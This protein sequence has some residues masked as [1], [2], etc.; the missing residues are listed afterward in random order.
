MSIEPYCVYLNNMPYIDNKGLLKL[1]CKNKNFG[2]PKEMN[3]TN[4]P[5][6]DLYSHSLIEKRREEFRQGIVPEGCHICTDHER[7]VGPKSFRK[8][9]L[10]NIKGLDTT[11]S[12]SF[13]ENDTT[14]RALDLRLG[15]TCN[16]VC[17]MCHPSES[18]KWYSISKDFSQEVKLESEEQAQRTKETNNPKFLNWAEYDQSWENIFSSIDENLLRIYLAGGEPFYIKKFSKYLE[19]ITE[20]S[21]NAFI[22]INTNATRMLTE[23]YVKKLKGKLNLRVSIDGYGKYDEYQRA[24]TDWK[25]KLEV[26]RQYQDNFKIISFDITVSSLTIRSLPDLIAFLEEN[27]PEP[28]I[29]L[30]PVVNRPGLEINNIPFDLRKNVLEYLKRKDNHTKKFVNVDQIV[31]ILQSGNANKKAE[32]QRYVKFW[33][34]LSKISFGE[35]DEQ[36]MNWIEK[37]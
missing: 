35:V 33:D 28:R 2:A 32:L 30:R 16:L 12:I 8:R 31:S 36:L 19:I 3:I 37:D 17:T 7:D 26:I 21:P 1:C 24:G 22:E 14:I 29:L 5:L 18:S 4:T 20:V 25:E 27:F 11:K 9:Q 34:R 13:Q 15:S 23:D 6:K 10:L